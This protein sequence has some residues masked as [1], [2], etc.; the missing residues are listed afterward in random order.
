MNNSSLSVHASFT[1]RW[2]VCWWVAG[3]AAAAAVF[4][5]DQIMRAVVYRHYLCL[6]ILLYPSFCPLHQYRPMNRREKLKHRHKLKLR[7]EKL[8]R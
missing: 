4:I 3:E 2:T 6:V 7:R 8:Q 1:C 5:I